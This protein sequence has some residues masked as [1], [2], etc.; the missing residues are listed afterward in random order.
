MNIPPASSIRYLVA[1]K[2]DGL[3][4]STFNQVAGKCYSPEYRHCLRRCICHSVKGALRRG[5]DLLLSTIDKHH[6]N[7]PLGA[8]IIVF[9]QNEDGERE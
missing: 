5:L 7:C 2:E 1:C 8:E 6:I 9:E 3:R 4:E